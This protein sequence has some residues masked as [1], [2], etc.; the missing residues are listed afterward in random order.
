MRRN[1]TVSHNARDLNTRTEMS[2]AA[3]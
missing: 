1:L 2:L 3:T